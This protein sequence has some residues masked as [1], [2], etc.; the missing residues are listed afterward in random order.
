MEPSYSTAAP[1]CKKKKKIELIF[2]IDISKTCFL[3]NEKEEF[4]FLR[5]TQPNMLAPEKKK[6][7]S[8]PSHSTVQFL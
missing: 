1:C 5:K 2:P 6:T 8:A 4:F 7:R 3:P